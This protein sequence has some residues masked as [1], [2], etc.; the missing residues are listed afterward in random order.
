MRE[1]RQDAGK[2]GETGLRN[3]AAAADQRAA[4]EAGVRRRRPGKPSASTAEP[5]SRKRRAATEVGQAPPRQREC[6]LLCQRATRSRQ[7]RVLSSID[8]SGAGFYAAQR[9]DDSMRVTE[10]VP[11]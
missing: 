10:R 7:I 1:R 4:S 3:P 6:P 11:A 9:L 5:E 8:T 2:G